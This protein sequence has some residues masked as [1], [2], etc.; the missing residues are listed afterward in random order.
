MDFGRR[1][2]PHGGLRGE[3]DCAG[4]VELRADLD[5]SGATLTLSD[6]ERLIGWC[7]NVRE[8]SEI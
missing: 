6:R 3:V 2:G 4:E 8:N 5:T 7:D 1:E